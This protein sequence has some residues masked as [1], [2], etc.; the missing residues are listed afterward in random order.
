MK[1]VALC[2]ILAVL[3]WLFTRCSDKLDIQKEYDFTL[4]SWYLQKSIK[5]G[6]AVEIRFTLE[7]SGNYQGTEYFIGYVQMEGKGEVFD[8]AG[9][10]L[11]NRETH[12]LDDMAGI[13]KSNPTKQVFTLYYRSLSDKKTQLK[14]IV[15]DSFGQETEL[16]ISF[17]NDNDS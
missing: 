5:N 4:S 8:Q 17:D 1:I 12:S 3:V 13:D 11:V 14:F 10:L 9:T 2:G 15:L 7:S 16:I 6:E